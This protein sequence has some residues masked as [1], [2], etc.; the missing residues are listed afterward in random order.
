M[1]KKLTMASELNCL[2]RRLSV[3]GSGLLFRKLTAIGFLIA[4]SACG[5]TSKLPVILRKIDLIE[6]QG[7]AFSDTFEIKRNGK[8]E[9][10]ME[11]HPREER[12][13]V[14]ADSFR[15][16]GLIEIRDDHND[17]SKVENVS[18]VT[19]EGQGVIYLFFLDSNEIGGKGVKSIKVRLVSTGDTLYKEN[20][21]ILFYI[22]PI[23]SHPL[24]F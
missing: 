8:Y 2:M 4:M 6:G 5:S 13:A 23:L 3:K 24:S 21:S 12:S 11:L 7:V 19:V 14:G 9:V 16:S 1:A 15:I 18:Y 22:R 17:I 10:A 20:R